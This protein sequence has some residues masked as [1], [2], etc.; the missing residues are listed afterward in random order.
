[1]VAIKKTWEQETIEWIRRTRPPIYCVLRHVSR[2]GMFRRISFYAIR[3][4]DH[5]Y[6]DGL[7]A[8]MTAYKLDKA[9]IGLRVSGCGMDMGFAVVHAFSRS[10]FPNGFRYRKDERHRNNDPSPVDKDGGYAL[11]CKWL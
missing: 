6:L 5:V 8:G 11:K 9:K 4:E 10:C 3:G 1:M 7:I 2:S